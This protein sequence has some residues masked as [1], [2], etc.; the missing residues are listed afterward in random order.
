MKCKY[1][2]RF[3]SGLAVGNI[4]MI[5]PLFWSS[6]LFLSM[7]IHA[8]SIPFI[9]NVL[10]HGVGIELVILVA[11]AFAFFKRWRFVLLLYI[12]YA[13]YMLPRLLDAILYY[14]NKRALTDTAFYLPTKVHT[15]AYTILLLLT[16]AAL[17]IFIIEALIAKRRGSSNSE[18]FF[19]N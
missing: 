19:N 5:G 14:Y 9:T 12:P 8:K 11:S 2:D 7:G 4:A 16:I 15:W 10:I 18:L 3:L 17:I 1:T 6:W 13:M